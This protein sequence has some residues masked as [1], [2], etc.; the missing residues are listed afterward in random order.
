VT[1]PDGWAEFTTAAEVNHHL[2]AHP[3]W[4]STLPPELYQAYVV[5]LL[6]RRRELQPTREL[7]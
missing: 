1:V 3:P 7:P 5:A 4:T 6:D 2:A